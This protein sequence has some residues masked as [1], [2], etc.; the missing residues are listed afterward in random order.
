MA[1]IV[2]LLSIYYSCA[3]LAEHGLLTQEE[4]FAC[5][6]TYQE[7]KVLFLAEDAPA[8]GTTL[9]PEQNTLAFRR[10]KAWEAANE[11]LVRQ[12]KAH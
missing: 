10:F 7:A 3:S 6:A 9:S 12:L 1:E 2:A 8:L 4:R 5:N 11:D